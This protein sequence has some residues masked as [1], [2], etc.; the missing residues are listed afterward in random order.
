[1][2]IQTRLQIPNSFLEASLCS[3]LADKHI[4]SFAS[5]EI[6]LLKPTRNRKTHAL[7]DYK[8]L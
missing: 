1:M 5:L 6:T 2:R 4:N 8:G 3:K 7:M